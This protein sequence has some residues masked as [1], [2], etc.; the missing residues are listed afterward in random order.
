MFTFNDEPITLA[1]LTKVPFGGKN[2]KKEEDE[3]TAVKKNA[4]VVYKMHT[5]RKRFDPAIGYHSNAGWYLDTYC[6]IT[7]NGQ[8]GLLRFY[9][10]KRT[11]RDGAQQSHTVYQPEHLI[12][13]ER[14]ELTV[15]GANKELQ[16]FLDISKFNADNTEKSGEPPIFYREDKVKDASTKI[17]TARIKNKAINLVTSQ[18]DEGGMSDEALRNLAKVLYMSDADDADLAIVRA[19]LLDIAEN[20][21]NDIVTK[22]NDPTTQLGALVRDA[23]KHNV[24]RYERSTM[25]W[26]ILENGVRVAQKITMVPPGNDPV[27]YLVKFCTEIDK[28]DYLAFIRQSVADIKEALEVH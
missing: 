4:P 10:N 13:N 15:E 7:H 24:I 16:Y 17:N 20:R 18:E 1:E 25:S 2:K 23:E 21:P 26:H 19:Y 3:T 11:V 5:S 9:T 14:G 6:N 22:F 27:S 12:I 28:N 8:I